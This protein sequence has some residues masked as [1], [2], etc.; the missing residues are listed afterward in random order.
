MVRVQEFM[1]RLGIKNQDELAEKLGLGQ[2]AISAW[3][4]GTNAPK[5]KTCVQLLKMGM[6]FRELFGDDFPDITLSQMKALSAGI[7]ENYE[8]GT[9][10]HEFD[11]KVE[12]S[13]LRLFGNLFGHK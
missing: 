7:K 11:K 3:N 5:H 2:S 4:A 12:D 8:N 10:E 1:N 13:V 6:T 9:P